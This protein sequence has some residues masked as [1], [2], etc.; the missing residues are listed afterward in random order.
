MLSIRPILGRTFLPGEDESGAKPLI[1]LSHHYW[2]EK[3]GSNPDVVGMNLQ[4]N[5]AVHQI[6]GVLL[7]V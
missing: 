7:P 6:I 1:I 2:R 4:M 3:F 5:N